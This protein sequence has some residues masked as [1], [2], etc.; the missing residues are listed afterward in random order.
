[1]NV[2]SPPSSNGWI[3]PLIMGSLL[4]KTS[5]TDPGCLS[6]I[7]IFSILDTGARDKEIPDSHPYQELCI[8]TQKIVSQLSEIWSSMFIPDP[9]L[10]FLPILNPISRG[11]WKKQIFS[12]CALYLSSVMSGRCNH[13]QRNENIYNLTRKRYNFTQSCVYLFGYPKLGLAIY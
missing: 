4:D 8:L 1:M 2:V 10:D 3:I 13:K 9:D 12:V 6:Q 7:R 11:H 5:V